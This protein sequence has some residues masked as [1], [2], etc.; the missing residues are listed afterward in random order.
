MSS[1][2]I[3]GTR[4]SPLALAQ[5]QQILKTL[6]SHHPHLS[7]QTRTFTTH[8][9]TLQ[10]LPDHDQPPVLEKGWFTGALEAALLEKQAHIIVHSLKDLPT[11]SAHS[12]LI[13]AAT[14][15]RAAANDLLISKW[16]LHSE[17]PLLDL[18][19]Q[20]T[21][22]TGSPRRQA[23]IR[24]LRPDLRTRSIR[25]NIGTRIEKLLCDSDLQAIILAQAGMDRLR[26]N[27]P[28]TLHSAPIP[29]HSM[30]PAPGQ[31]ALA[32][33][34]HT[35]HKEIISILSSIHHLFTHQATTAERAFLK[36]LGGGCLAP[37]AAYAEFTSLKSSLHG[38]YAPSHLAK[39]VSLAITAPPHHDPIEL[40][41][42]LAHLI[43]LT[44][45]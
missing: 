43:R 37:I 35:D 10:S 19:P 30:L 9:D 4:G 23:Q 31:G 13:I 20:S 40:G 15:I 45:T 36:A 24:A 28:S 27:L 34:T 7:F 17:N 22:G 21:I 1:A 6:Q 41:S 39:P 42:R 11:E 26:L 16:P 8:G 29:I 5:T 3:L 33:Q 12:S 14:P 25:G 32:I 44:A 2:I 38:F 18:P